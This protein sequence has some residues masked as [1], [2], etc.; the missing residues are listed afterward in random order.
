LCGRLLG[1]SV[2]DLVERLL[3]ERLLDEPAGMLLDDVGLGY[4][5]I[6]TRPTFAGWRW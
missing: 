2:A 5:S 4:G 1:E 6:G 3:S